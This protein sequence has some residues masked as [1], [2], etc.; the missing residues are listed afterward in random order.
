MKLTSSL[1][2]CCLF[3]AG[4][5]AVAATPMPGWF[6]GVMGGISDFP[7]QTYTFSTPL[8]LSQFTNNEL[9]GLN[10]AK[11]KYSIGGNAAGEFGYRWKKLRIEGELLF[12][13][14]KFS[15]INY[16]NAGG[17][18]NCQLKGSA[19]SSTG[20]VAVISN[21]PADLGVATSGIFMS[22]QTITGA[23]L[24][25][26]YYELYQYGGQ[27]NFFP[28]AGIG[29]GYATAHSYLRIYDNSTDTRLFNQSFSSTHPVGQIIIGG[30][31]MLDSFS[32]FGVDFRYMDSFSTSST[33]STLS[34][35]TQN[36]LKI[37][38]AMITISLNYSLDKV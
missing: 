8:T 19:A 18:I 12:N 30:G 1:G 16:T 25:N 10:T 9:T 7:S 34:S 28:Y 2:A 38:S 14:A 27:G 35:S 29:V 24:A 15:Q 26:L 5:Y 17:R 20:C 13:G 36:N 6:V 37:K 3:L 21:V 33:S 22:G 23:F 31:Y 4:N 11:V 32:V